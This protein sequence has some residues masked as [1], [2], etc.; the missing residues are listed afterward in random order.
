M[1][2]REWEPK[3]PLSP[4]VRV[5]LLLVATGASWQGA[6]QQAGLSR[7]HLERA[8]L[9]EEGRQFMREQHALYLEEVRRARIVYA[10]QR[11]ARYLG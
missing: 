11:E 2:N 6:A 10:L 9:T 1:A 5:G 4:R 8:R 3:R 7:K